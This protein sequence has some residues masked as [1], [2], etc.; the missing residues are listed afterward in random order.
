[1]RAGHYWWQKFQQNNTQLAILPMQWSGT[2][3]LS[4]T[5]RDIQV[6]AVLLVTIKTIKISK[7]ITD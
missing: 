1:M 5:H 4:E 7:S 2:I 3:D 6:Y